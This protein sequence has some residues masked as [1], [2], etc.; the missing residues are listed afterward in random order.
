[1]QQ[2]RSTAGNMFIYIIGAI[3]L[4]GLLIVALKGSFQEGSGID[5]EKNI[6]LVNQVQRYGAELE[7]G[8]S[9][10]LRSGYSESELRFAH[11]NAAS[12]YGLITDIPARQVFAPEGGGVEWRAPPAGLQTTLT[13][14]TFSGEAKVVGVGSNG[15]DPS[16]AELIAFLMYV[17]KSFCLEVNN[18]NG[19]TNPSGNPPT[20]ADGFTWNVPFI[21]NFAAVGGINST[22]NELF[23][24]MQGCVEASG[25]Y[26][27][28]RVLLAR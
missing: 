13:P 18:S 5:P 20:D 1:M 12:A 27:Y 6:L 15:T 19:I 3:F 17:P 21:G 16:A 8:V 26:H 22:G 9:Y 11:P 28:Y 2:N 25:A 23:G 14:W 7:R 24:K 10:I 4:M